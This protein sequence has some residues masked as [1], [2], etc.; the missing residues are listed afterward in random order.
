MRY[1]HPR[2][3]CRRGAKEIRLT[4]RLLATPAASD[5]RRQDP[6]VIVLSGCEASC[7]SVTSSRTSSVRHAGSNAVP[8]MQQ[9]GDEK[10]QW[11]RLRAVLLIGDLANEVSPSQC[12]RSRPRIVRSSFASSPIH[13]RKSQLSITLPATGSIKRSSAS[14]GS[15]RFPTDDDIELRADI[16][17]SPVLLAVRIL[18]HGVVLKGM[19]SS[20]FWRLKAQTNRSERSSSSARRFIA[21]AFIVHLLLVKFQYSV[22]ESLEGHIPIAGNA[23]QRRR[24][25]RPGDARDLRRR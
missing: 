15:Y 11:R 10:A 16:V 13:M 12:S 4:S 9:Q 17:E 18:I 7:C 1:K 19:M 23:R 5:W 2:R 6:I 25:P 24:A 3:R 21:V 22:T 8:A 20:R 14:N